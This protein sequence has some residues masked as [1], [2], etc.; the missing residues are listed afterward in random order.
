MLFSLSSANRGAH[1]NGL[2]YLLV[3][4]SIHAF[5][6]SFIHYGG[7][8]PL[9]VYPSICRLHGFWSITSTVWYKTKFG[10]QNFGYQLWCLFLPKASFG[11]WL[12]SLPVSVCVYQSLAYPRNKR[13]PVQ[14]WI[15]KF[16]PKMQNTLVKVPIVLRPIDLHLQGQM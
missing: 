1:I 4:P 7:N 10:S 14:S 2:F 5:I 12:L 8:I 15:N 6:H 13:A 9:S 11:P 3:H 16:G